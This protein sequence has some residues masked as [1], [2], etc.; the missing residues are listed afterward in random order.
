VAAIGVVVTTLFSYMFLDVYATPGRS[1][2]LQGLS[3]AIVPAIEFAFLVGV[4]MLLLRSRASVIVGIVLVL[5]KLAGPAIA[6]EIVVRADYAA[7][8]RTP[9]CSGAPPETQAAFDGLNHPAPFTVAWEVSG[10]ICAAVLAM[11]DVPGVRFWARCCLHV[12]CGEQTEGPLTSVIP[13]QA[14]IRIKLPRLGSNLSELSRQFSGAL[15]R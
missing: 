10:D 15:R 4:A 8:P 5:A 13:S 1:G 6:G 7:Y 14:A 9:E 3:G 12:A 2:A 11:V